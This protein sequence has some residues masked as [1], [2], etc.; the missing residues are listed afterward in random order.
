MFIDDAEVE[1]VTERPEVH[2]VFQRDLDKLENWADRYL[3][4][5]DRRK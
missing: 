2:A 3:V 4:W 5:F 1:G